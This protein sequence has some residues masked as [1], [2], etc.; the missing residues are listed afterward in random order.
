MDGADA[1]SSMFADGFGGLQQP[2]PD[3]LGD[4]EVTL[5]CSLEE[6][7]SGCCKSFSY[8]IDEVQH[9]GKTVCKKACRKMIQV[10][11]GF[12]DSTVLT[13]KGLGNQA[14][15]MENS[16]LVVKFSQT[17]NKNFRRSGD[18]LILTLKISL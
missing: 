5:E 16:N 1:R 8:E 11:P 13:F 4:V 7:Y 9:D 12:S 10:D 3:Q 2:R 14:P 18:N 6:F 17:E 15:K